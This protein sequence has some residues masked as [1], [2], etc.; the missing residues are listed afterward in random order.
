MT[1]L[2]ARERFNTVCDWIKNYNEA[3]PRYQRH[4]RAEL[5]EKLKERDYLRKTFVGINTENRVPVGF[6]VKITPTLIIN[7][8]YK[9]LTPS[10]LYN[11]NITEEPMFSVEFHEETQ[12]LTFEQVQEG[13]FFINVFGSFCIKDD[14]RGYTVI[15]LKDGSSSGY[16]ESDVDDDTAIKKIFPLIKK[17]HFNKD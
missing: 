8:A 3:S 13:Q 9:R 7:E 14:E 12:E 4:Y 6:E 1:T 11:N 15:A 16:Y 10:I 2:T 5:E 17:I